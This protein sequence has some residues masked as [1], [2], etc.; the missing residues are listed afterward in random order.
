MPSWY[1]T[2]I[3]MKVIYIFHLN[4]TNK[5]GHIWTLEPENGRYNTGQYVPNGTVE[6][7]VVAD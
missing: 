3:N 2:D 4:F 1:D 5:I 7:A 6:R